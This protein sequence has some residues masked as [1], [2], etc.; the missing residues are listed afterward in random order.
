MISSSSIS[1]CKLDIWTKNGPSRGTEPSSIIDSQA[2]LG[3]LGRFNGFASNPKP[4]K[5]PNPTKVF[6][7]LIKILLWISNILL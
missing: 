1:N 2:A 5:P 4:L 7:I 3:A 6:T